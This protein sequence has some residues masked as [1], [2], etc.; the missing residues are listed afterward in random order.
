MKD[1]QTLYLI[2]GS[3]I[4]YRSYFGMI[5]NRLTNS[6]GQPTGAIFAFINSLMKII[7]DEKPDYIGMV[8]D[9][10]EKTF[11]HKIYADYKATREAT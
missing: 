8:F 5:R 11:R 7:N 4:A 1:K 6:A 10:P 2:D 3:A 9:S